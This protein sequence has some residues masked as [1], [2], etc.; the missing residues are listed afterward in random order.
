M[1]LGDPIGHPLVPSIPSLPLSPVLSNLVNGIRYQDIQLLEGRPGE[2]QH[3]GVRLLGEP[4][5]PFLQDVDVAGQ[6]R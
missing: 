6:R 4:E 1:L 2:L 3:T 5:L